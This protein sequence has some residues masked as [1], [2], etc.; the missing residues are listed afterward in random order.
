MRLANGRLAQGSDGL[1]LPFTLGSSGGVLTSNDEGATWR[2][3]GPLLAGPGAGL[4]YPAVAESEPGRLLLLA[5]TA[6]HRIYRS[7]SPDGGATWTTPTEVTT[8]VA[9]E[10]PLALSPLARGAGLMVAWNH[11]SRRGDGRDRVRLSV[12]TSAD[13]MRWAAPRPSLRTRRSS[14]PAPRSPI[15]DEPS[16]FIATYVQL[17]DPDSGSGVLQSVEVTIP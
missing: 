16:R 12:A 11:H 15:D 6:T 9:P 7:E 1:M 10:A 17:A 4:R 14:P 3:L 2:R 8:L 13:G 5:A